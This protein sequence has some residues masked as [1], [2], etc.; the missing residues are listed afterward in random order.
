M[1]RTQSISDADYAA[2]VERL[3]TLGYDVTKLRKV[4]QSAAKAPPAPEG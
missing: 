2:H 1:A 4:P 3:R